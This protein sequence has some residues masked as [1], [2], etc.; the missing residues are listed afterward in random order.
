MEFS[1]VH[2]GTP[3][4]IFVTARNV[5]SATLSSG[6]GVM[7]ALPFVSTGSAESGYEGYAVKFPA[8]TLTG[9]LNHLGLFAGVVANQ[10]IAP[11]AFGRVQVWGTISSVLVHGT[12]AAPF[13]GNGAGWGDATSV[14]RLILRPI[15]FYSMN[16]VVTQ[17]GIFGMMDCATTAMT[18]FYTFFP[19]GYA[20]PFTD[21]YTTVSTD[22]SWV[23]GAL[24]TTATGWCKAFIRCL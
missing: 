17:P 7:W 3:E 2:R 10:D 1:R 4:Q 9:G 24:G 19:G 22:G 13:V 16:T 21:T 8:T 12:T 14:Y 15:H 23:I 20:L 6:R 11:G 18:Q 5:D